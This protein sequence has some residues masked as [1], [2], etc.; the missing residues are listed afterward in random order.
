MVTSFNPPMIERCAIILPGGGGATFEN[1]IAL[2]PEYEMDIE[3]N[4]FVPDGVDAPER[5]PLKVGSRYEIGLSG[6]KI[7]GPT[8]VIVGKADG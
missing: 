1:M 2:W 4:T 7:G 6:P 8:Y 3:G 5:E